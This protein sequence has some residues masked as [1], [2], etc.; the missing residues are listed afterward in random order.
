MTKR[1]NVGGSIS[2]EHQTKRRAG[3]RVRVRGAVRSSG[4]VCADRPGRARLVERWAFYVCRETVENVNDLWRA[5][6][7]RSGV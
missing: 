4:R 7:F 6:R 1:Q 3:Q 5:D 2:L